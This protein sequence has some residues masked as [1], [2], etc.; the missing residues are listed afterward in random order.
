M[1]ESEEFGR[2]HYNHIRSY[3]VEQIDGRLTARGKASKAA[4][5]DARPACPRP[6]ASSST[7]CVCD[8][9]PVAQGIAPQ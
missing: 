6:S 8:L 1:I 9:N 5:G 2:S 7:R 3:A 4:P